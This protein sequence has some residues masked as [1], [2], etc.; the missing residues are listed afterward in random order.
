M[1]KRRE[2]KAT[3]H[4]WWK[5]L[6]FVLLPFAV[7]F[8]EA[9]LRTGILESHFKLGELT[10]RQRQVQEKMRA[11]RVEESELRRLSRI[12]S[13]APDLGLVAPAPGQVVII[14]LDDDWRE[15]P[16]V[17]T[18]ESTPENEHHSRSPGTVAD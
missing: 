1:T 9:W 7:V 15:D 17:D 3:L 10:E 18:T 16:I 8:S 14:E 12:N 5:Y 2:P 13:A 6:P 11:L 4:G